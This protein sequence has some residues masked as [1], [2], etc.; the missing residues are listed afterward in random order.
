MHRLD[1]PGTIGHLDLHIHPPTRITLHPFPQPSFPIS[2]STIEHAT[3]HPYGT[4]CVLDA[5]GQADYASAF[6]LPATATELTAEAPAAGTAAAGTAAAGTA[7]AVTRGMPAALTAAATAATAPAE[8]PVSSTVTAAVAADVPIT[9]TAAAAAAAAVAAP[10]AELPATN[11]AAGAVVVKTPASTPATALPADMSASTTVTAPAAA[12]AI[13]PA[14]ASNPVQ[15]PSAPALP[16]PPSQNLNL[17]LALLNLFNPSAAGP[18]PGQRLAQ[19]PGQEQQQN[20]GG[21]CIPVER[22]AS[23]HVLAAGDSITQGSVPS[24]GFNYP[25][26]I[27]LEELLRKKLGP[28]TRAIDAGGS[29]QQQQQQQQ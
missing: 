16:T 17:G 12:A 9:D 13:T 10:T 14:P 7:A 21:Y 8:V 4:A 11:D 2:S 5:F 6:L 27:K 15:A 24:R 28:R 1:F 19:N 18:P 20:P 23:F 22:R 3:H 25:Y 29:Q 26:A